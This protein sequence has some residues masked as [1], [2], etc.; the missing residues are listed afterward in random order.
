MTA[1][2]AALAGGTIPSELDAYFAERAEAIDRG[3]TD[4]RDGLRHLAGHGLLAHP[5]LATSC[6]VI[7]GVARHSLTSAFSAWA[8]TMVA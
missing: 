6:A 4:V 7:E 8:H 1:V 2:R 3:I 5:E